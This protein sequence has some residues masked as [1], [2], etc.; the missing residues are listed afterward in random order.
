MTVRLSRDERH[1]LKGLAAAEGVSLADAIRLCIRR[2]HAE[3]FGTAA[4]K[5]GR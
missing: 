2:A 4:K 3:R 5:G 1:M